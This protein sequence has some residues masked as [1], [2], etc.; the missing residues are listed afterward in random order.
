MKPTTPRL[1]PRPAHPRR[2]HCRHLHDDGLVLQPRTL[3]PPAEAVAQAP[4]GH[5]E[6]SL[7][8]VALVA[9]PREELDAADKREAE[10]A[11]EQ[12]QPEARRPVAR[13][14]LRLLARVRAML[15]RV[16]AVVGVAGRRLA[17]AVDAV[18]GCGAP[19]VGARRGRGRER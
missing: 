10:E 19:A 18:A 11:A 2:G 14:L 8:H 15:A 7:G 9:L 13:I 12:H 1:R 4:L 16:H 3:G 6:A 5:G 17:A